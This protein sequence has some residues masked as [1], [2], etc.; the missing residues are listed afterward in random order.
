MKWKWL[1]KMAWRDSRKSRGRLLLFMTSIVVGIAALGCPFHQRP[2]RLGEP[3]HLRHLVER[4]AHRVVDRRPQ[5]PVAS[6]PLDDQKLAMPA[7]D[8]QQRVGKVDAV[9]QPGGER[10][11]LEV[12]DRQ[13]RPPGQGLEQVAAGEA[14][15]GPEGFAQAP[16][17]G[18]QLLEAAVLVLVGDQLQRV[19]TVL[20]GPRPAQHRGVDVGRVDHEGNVHRHLVAQQLLHYAHDQAQW[21]RLRHELLDKFR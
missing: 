6:H 19:T 15:V 4:L 8:Q 10:M 9:G 3:Q 5:A 7:R 11:R 16:A 12:V 20:P 1:A 2:A 21:Q 18:R 13:E 14:D 17:V